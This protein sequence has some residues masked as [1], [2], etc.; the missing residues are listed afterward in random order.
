MISACINHPV[1]CVRVCVCVRPKTTGA[2][3]G[4]GYPSRE[5]RAA[6]A[7]DVLALGPLHARHLP[8]ARVVQG[9]RDHAGHLQPSPAAG[10]GGAALHCVGPGTLPR[11]LFF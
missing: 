4:G 11:T 6:A 10:A 7:G 9:V 8:G 1:V 2:G 5:P 3:A